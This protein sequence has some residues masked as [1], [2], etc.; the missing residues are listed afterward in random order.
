M[1]AALADQ[2]LL[3][4][5]GQL[6]IV[7]GFHG[8]LTTALGAGAQV[9][10]IAEHLGQGDKGIDLLG[11]GAHLVALNLATAPMYSSGTITHT[12]MMGSSRTGS[13]SRIASLK[14]MEPAILKAIS[15]ESTSW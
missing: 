6:H 3:Q 12:F 15:E 4:T 1:A 14:A 11:A 10:S 2:L 7:A 9:G 5:L 8:V 13:A